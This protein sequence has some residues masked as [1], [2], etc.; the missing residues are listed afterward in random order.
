MLQLYLAVV[1]LLIC[2]TPSWLGWCSSLLFHFLTPYYN[3]S[4]QEPP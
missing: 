2:R 1:A 4:N 3:G